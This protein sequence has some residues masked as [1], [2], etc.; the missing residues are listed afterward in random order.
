MPNESPDGDTNDFFSE[1]TLPRPSLLLHALLAYVL[2][3]KYRKQITFLTTIVDS[4]LRVS[5][6]AGK[7]VTRRTTVRAFTRMMQCVWLNLV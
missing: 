7:L 4:C 6:R 5:I 1:S 3:V 2:R